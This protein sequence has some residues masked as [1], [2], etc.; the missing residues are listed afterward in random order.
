MRLRDRT[1]IRRVVVTA[2]N[3]GS[4]GFARIE[5]HEWP[6]E[7]TGSPGFTRIENHDRPKTGQV[8]W[9]AYKDG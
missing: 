7:K 9:L 2:E 6:A 1:A 8:T 5:N 3:H 4:P